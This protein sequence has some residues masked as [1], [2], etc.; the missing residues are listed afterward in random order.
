MIN[1]LPV[2]EIKDF[3]MMRDREAITARVLVVPASFRRLGKK[4]FLLRQSQDCGVQ[5]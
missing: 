3:Y 4:N 2:T 1:G 5:E